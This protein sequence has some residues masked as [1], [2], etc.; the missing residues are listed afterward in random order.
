MVGQVG[1]DQGGEA[2]GRNGFFTFGGK[3]LLAYLEARAV[4]IL[5]IEDIFSTH[6]LAR[7]CCLA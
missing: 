5:Q 1:S 4:Y 7:C 6:Y 2:N 3:W